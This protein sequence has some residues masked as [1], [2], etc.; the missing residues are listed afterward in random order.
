MLSSFLEG[1]EKGIKNVCGRSVW[2]KA[3]G[4]VLAVV[5]LKLRKVKTLFSTWMLF[6]ASCLPSYYYMAW[7]IFYILG[8]TSKVERGEMKHLQDEREVICL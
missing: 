2:K 1:I 5:Y 3:R 4:D 8:S 6:T 7:H